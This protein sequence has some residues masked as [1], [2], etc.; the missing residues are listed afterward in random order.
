M[1]PL[2][3]PSSW[4]TEYKKSTKLSLIVFLG[5]FSTI[6]VFQTYFFCGHYPLNPWKHRA[7][8]SA[9]VYL[10]PTKKGKNVAELFLFCGDSKKKYPFFWI[11][12]SNITGSRFF[13]I[14]RRS[15]T[16]GWIISKV[17]IK[18]KCEISQFLGKCFEHTKH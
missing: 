11:F 10:K 9:Q 2:F 16:S 12:G 17:D 18:Y 1:V 8:I 4:R 5:W 14:F 3:L 6:S 15:F 7:D 13:E